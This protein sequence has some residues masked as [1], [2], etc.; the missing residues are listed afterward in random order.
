MPAMTSPLMA[1]RFSGMT[2]L[3]S[4]IAMLACWSYPAGLVVRDA[5]HGRAPHH[6]G[7]RPH[8]EELAKQASRRMKPPNWKMRGFRQTARA[9]LG[10]RNRR[11]RGFLHPDLFVMECRAAERCDGLGPGEHV[12]AASADM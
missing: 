5:R 6:E 4:V 2:L 9:N 10:Y 3:W 7:Q 11:R 8:P 12:D 1:L